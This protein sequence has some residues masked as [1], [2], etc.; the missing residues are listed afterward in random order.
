MIFLCLKI[1]HN[2][3]QIKI[4]VNTCLGIIIPSQVSDG[5]AMASIFVVL[6]LM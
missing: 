5:S 4:S 2:A 1:I 3:D 6:L